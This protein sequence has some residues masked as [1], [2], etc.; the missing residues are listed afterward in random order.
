MAPRLAAG[1]DEQ[2]PDRSP[3]DEG[4]RESAEQSL[5]LGQAWPGQQEQ[6][7]QK[8]RHDAQQCGRQRTAEQQA[9]DH[10]AKDDEKEHP[11]RHSAHG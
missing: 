11:L 4:H 7:A 9:A 1:S 2:A 6:P 5:P 8:D 3:G 10:A